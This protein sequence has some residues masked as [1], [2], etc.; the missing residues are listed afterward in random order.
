MKPIIGKDSNIIISININ[1]HL[2]L[3]EKV[4]ENRDLPIWDL[5]YQRSFYKS[6]GNS[7]FMVGKF[8][9]VFSRMR[10]PRHLPIGFRIKNKRRRL[11]FSPKI[12]P[13][14]TRHHLL[15]LKI[16]YH[17]SYFK[18]R[19]KFLVEWNSVEKMMVQIFVLWGCG[20]NL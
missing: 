7:R 8:L 20:L 3:K 16:I 12:N 2:L 17:I 15:S 19:K 5:L 4:N 6:R 13:I 11:T 10:N 9:R 14:V 1:L 18:S